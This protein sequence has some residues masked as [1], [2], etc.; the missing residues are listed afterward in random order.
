MD[1]AM[2]AL[3]AIAFM[4]MSIIT[5]AFAQSEWCRLPTGVS[6]TLLDAAFT[7]NDNGY[8]VG[9]SGTAIRTT[10][11]GMSWRSM[12]IPTQ[13]EYWYFSKIRF[14]TSRT[15][16]IVGTHLI[17]RYYTG[18]LFS[19]VDGG[20][21]W[22][23]VPLNDFKNYYISGINFP[24]LDIG[25]MTVIDSNTESRVL[26]TTDAGKTWSDIHQASYWISDI[27]FRDTHVGM[28]QAS[29]VEPGDKHIRRTFD[30]WIT[31][32]DVYPCGTN[33]VNLSTLTHVAG[34]TWVI[35]DYSVIMRTDDDGATWNDLAALNDSA[36]M[37]Q[38][39]DIKFLDD[40]IGYAVCNWPTR[41][42]KTTNG[43]VDWQSERIGKVSWLSSVTIT[44]EQSAYA[45]GDSGTVIKIC[46]LPSDT[47][48]NSGG[49]PPLE[50]VRIW[51]AATQIRFAPSTNDRSAFIYDLL[52]RSMGA[53]PV[54]SETSSLILDTTNL[55][56]GIYWCRLGNETAEFVIV[57]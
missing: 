19:T 21:S 14:T 40:H 43:G 10:D 50:I 27:T 1:I 49:I 6:V 31:W 4:F 22:Q 2:K 25:Y 53:V 30:G 26:R 28:V 41:I 17:E 52:G 36:H 15:G 18:V 34:T 46:T 56:P 45:T 33:C 16:F 35:T 32:D 13:G 57:R 38:I 20:D 3:Y 51:P 5:T 44:D 47:R 8:V 12:Q 39:G 7:S 9:D 24:Q 11:G 54:S 55:P 42:Y 48:T 23:R 29:N 37:M